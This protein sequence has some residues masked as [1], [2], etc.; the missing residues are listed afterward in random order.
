VV[1]DWSAASLP[2]QGPDSIWWRCEGLNLEPRTRNP[3]T[4][5]EAYCQL[6]LLELL[7]RSVE[8][9]RRTL[10]GYDFPLGFPSSSL[11]PWRVAWEMISHRVLDGV[12]RENRNNRWEVAADLNRAY[13]GRDA[14]FWGCPAAAA[15]EFLKPMKPADLGAREFRLTEL[16][17]SHKRPK[18]VWQML[19]AGSVGSQSLLGIPYVSLLRGHQYLSSQSRIWP[20]ETGLRVPPRKDCLVVHA[21]VWPSLA[22]A[23]GRAYKLKD[24]AQVGSLARWL[25]E[26]DRRGELDRWFAGPPDLTD[27][28]RQ[29]AILEEG[30]ILGV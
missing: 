12:Q 14:P 4:R 29:Q 28:E 9:G 11:G 30:W 10:V 20:F 22:P 26:A 21:E 7:V 24:K 15:S 5:F 27:S 16:R 3:R 13:T 2:K 19:G 25:A 18:S 23:S 8:L 17:V 1:V 6:Q